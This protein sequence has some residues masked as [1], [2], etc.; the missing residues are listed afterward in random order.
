M[1]WRGLDEGKKDYDFHIVH[2]PSSSPRGI[3]GRPGHEGCYTSN[4]LSLALTDFLGGE[5]LAQ[6]LTFLDV[7]PHHMPDYRGPE[8]ANLREYVEFFKRLHLPYYEEARRYW[9]RAEQDGFFDEANELWIYLP[10]TLKR[11]IELYGE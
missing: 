4:E 5:G 7:G 6:L 8:V 1:I 9:Q 11:L 3:V 10:D 2:H